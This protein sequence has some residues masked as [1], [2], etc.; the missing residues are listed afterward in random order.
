MLQRF[1]W[2][3]HLSFILRFI[4]MLLSV[5]F[6]YADPLSVGGTHDLLAFH[7]EFEDLDPVPVT[8]TQQIQ[9]ILVGN[10]DQAE[11]S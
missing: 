5:S 1:E 7:S 8:M 3:K 10:L 11:S 2:E 6:N 9:Y 4:L